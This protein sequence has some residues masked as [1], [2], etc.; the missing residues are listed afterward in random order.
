MPFTSDTSIFNIYLFNSIE[1]IYLY[2]NILY[3]IIARDAQTTSRQGGWLWKF[4]NFEGGGGKLIG[5]NRQF[6]AKSPKF[7]KFFFN[8]NH[9]FLDFCQIS[10]EI[11]KGGPKETFLNLV[12]KIFYGPLFNVFLDSSQNIL[13]SSPLRF[14]LKFLKKSRVNFTLVPPLRFFPE[15]YTPNTPLWATLIIAMI[16]LDSG[17]KLKIG[18]FRHLIVNK[19]SS[20]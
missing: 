5:F 16:A 14:S 19:F 9:N 8:K 4:S 2:F 10:I 11:S 15:G 20:I 13:C 1:V 18:H 3:P 12:Q 17:E 7:K 6:L